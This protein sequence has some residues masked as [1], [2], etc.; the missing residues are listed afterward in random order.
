M[1]QI[2]ICEDEQAD[3]ERLQ[4]MLHTILNKYAVERQITCC[5]SGEELLDSGIRFHLIFMDIVMEGRNGIDIGQEIYNRNH[6]VKIIYQTNFGEYCREAMNTVH[7]FAYIEKPV[8]A[9]MLEQQVAEFLKQ[10]RK[11]EVQLEFHSVSFEENGIVAEK[12]S[13]LLP[14]S[15]I[16]YFE[17]IKT[18]KKVKIVTESV[19]YE[20]PDVISSL[21]ERMQPYGFETSCRGILVNLRNV[22]KIKGYEVVLRN[23]ASVPLS[24]KRVTEFKKRLNECVRQLLL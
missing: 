23:G 13:I 14:V 21:G 22:M 19:V 5:G 8:D 10:Y 17:Y 7:A 1:L 15:A 20:Y 3:R 24:Q 12:P 2:A 11:E 16:Q 4:E 9:K 6:T 18:K